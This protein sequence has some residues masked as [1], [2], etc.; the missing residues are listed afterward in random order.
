MQSVRWW[1][2]NQHCSLFSCWADQPRGHPCRENHGGCG[3]RGQRRRGG[4]AHAQPLQPR[5]LPGYV[6]ARR[7]L[8]QGGHQSSTGFR[9]RRGSRP[10]AQ[11]QRVRQG[12]WPG[13]QGVPP[14]QTQRLRSPAAEG[15]RVY[16]KR[17]P[18]RKGAEQS[19][20]F[21]RPRG[22]VPVRGVRPH[23]Q[24]DRQ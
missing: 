18:L 21:P 1:S 23:R 14:S 17:G 19:R 12:P 10:Q 3:R 4:R 11:H 20:L 8:R 9:R 24:P 5:P 15:V 6:A 22:L 16:T 7:S 2:G 13:E